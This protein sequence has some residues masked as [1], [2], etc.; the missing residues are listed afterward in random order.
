ME[1]TQSL[2]VELNLRGSVA[3]AECVSWRQRKWPWQ[4]EGVGEKQVKA[5]GA[6]SGPESGKGHV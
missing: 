6:E 3:E 2:P 1:E 5:Q 4:L